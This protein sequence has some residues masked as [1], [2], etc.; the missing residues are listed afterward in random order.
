LVVV[1]MIFFVTNALYS[2]IMQNAIILN[3]RFTTPWVAGLGNPYPGVAPRSRDN[4]G[5]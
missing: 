3:D 4:P 2:Q 5:L 1:A